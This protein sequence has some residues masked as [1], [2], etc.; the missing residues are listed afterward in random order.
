MERKIA[1]LRCHESQI[2][3][4]AELEGFVRRWT[5]A[6][7]E[8]SGLGPGSYAEVFQVVDTR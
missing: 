1:A 3:D 6:T 5:A 7:A 8:L 4:P 2:G